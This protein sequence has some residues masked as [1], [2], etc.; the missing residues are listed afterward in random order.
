M[1][2]LKTMTT[3][4]IDGKPDGVRVCRCTL[5]TITTV[6]VPRPLLQRAKQI[7]KLPLR[8]VYYLISDVD[9]AISKLYVGQTTQG[10]ARLDDHN[11]KKDFWNK[12]IM[13]LAEDDQFSL[14]N[15]SALEQFS[16]RK[17]RE[18]KRYDVE[19]KQD[20]HYEISQYQQP[21]IEQIYD[22]IAFLMGSFGYQLEDREEV[23]ANAKVFHAARHKISAHGIY[24]GETFDV[25]EGSEINLARKPYTQAS[26]RIRQDLLDD[27]DIRVR[28]DGLG[29]LLKSVSFKSPSS[30]SEFVLGGSI[31]GWTAW[32]DADGKTLDALYR[33]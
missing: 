24:T 30:A 29:V 17:A 15:I 19:N 12:A 7:D 14:D 28:E 22:E 26:A 32:I 31:N 5:S 23:E 21:I 27:G 25:L 9:G 16:I 1:P 8:G 6:F 18:S 4:F 2:R 11:A 13:F 3:Q 10:L 33:Q 20:P